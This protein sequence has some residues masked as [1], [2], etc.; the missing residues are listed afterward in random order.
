MT[1]GVTVIG[2]RIRENL[3]LLG[4]L[5]AVSPLVAQLIATLG[6]DDVELAE[7]ETV[8][9]R[10]P[11]IASRVLS[12]ANAAAYA[13]LTP[14]TTIRSALLRLGLIRV[15]RLA[16]F[17]TLYSSVPVKQALRATFW[18]HSLAVAHVAEALGRRA[19]AAAV[20]VDP[21]VTFLGGLLHDIGLLVL[22]SHYPREHAA[23]LAAAVANGMPLSEAERRLLSIDHAEVGGYLGEHWSLPREIVEVIRFHHRD[24][25]APPDCQ[26]A[27]AI[28]RLADALC[29]S[30][31]AWDMGERGTIAIGDATLA[32]WGLDGKSLAAALD[33]ARGEVE[34]A[35]AV[36]ESI[37]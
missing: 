7:V 8:I 27:V 19:E 21:D 17:E 20:L 26:T 32:A 3:E 4:D 30:Q 16:M 34:Q 6:R 13:S 11:V 28:V 2:N 29:S 1:G 5:P 33:D 22:A 37:R 15:R 12:A 25:P 24:D 14:T 10:D 31:P 36:L 23:A 18:R 9:L 35:T